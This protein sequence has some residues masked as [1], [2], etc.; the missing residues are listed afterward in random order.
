MRGSA[1]LLLSMND[2]IKKYSTFVKYY[3]SGHTD[4]TN[5]IGMP[6]SGLS[7]FLLPAGQCAMFIKKRLLR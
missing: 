6:L 1:V 3:Q 2:I 4:Y 7:T 5:G